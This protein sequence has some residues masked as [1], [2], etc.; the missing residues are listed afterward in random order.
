MF[1]QNPSKNVFPPTE[2]RIDD[3]NQHRCPARKFPSKRDLGSTNNN[4]TLTVHELPEAGYPHVTFI[5]V[6]DDFNQFHP[7]TRFNSQI[8]TTHVRCCKWQALTLRPTSLCHQQNLIPIVRY[9]QSLLSTLINVQKGICQ[10][11]Q[12][13]LAM[14]HRSQ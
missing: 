2:C 6:A 3:V 5:R 10:V 8:Q 1:N 12:I 11:Y 4:Q 9:Y 7:A 14:H 13:C